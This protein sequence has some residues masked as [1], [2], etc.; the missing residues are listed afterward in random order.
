MFYDGKWKFCIL[1]RIKKKYIRSRRNK[2]KIESD[3]LEEELPRRIRGWR[4]N[5]LVFGCAVGAVAMLQRIE[6]TRYYLGFSYKRY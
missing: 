5:R 4:C 3:E 2:K 6:G 1:L